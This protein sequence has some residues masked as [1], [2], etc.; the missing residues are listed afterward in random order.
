MCSCIR[1]IV[2]CCDRNIKMA[3]FRCICIGE[4]GAECGTTIALQRVDNG[5]RGTPRPLSN[6]IGTR[7]HRCFNGTLSVPM[8]N[9][10]VCQNLKSMI[11][12]LLLQNLDIKFIHCFSKLLNI[13]LKEE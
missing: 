12:A 2:K 5:L 4:V 7:T 13:L 9:G 3:P 6:N 10:I 11:H 1:D 8:E